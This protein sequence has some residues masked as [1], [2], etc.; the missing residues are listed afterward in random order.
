MYNFRIIFVSFLYNYT[1][2]KL[3]NTEDGRP[4]K[5]E[6]LIN[7]ALKVTVINI[8]K[9]VSEKETVSLINTLYKARYMLRN[10]LKKYICF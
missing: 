7:S 5:L 1:K 8:I 10:I 3:Y 2:Y 9:E 6:E 4:L